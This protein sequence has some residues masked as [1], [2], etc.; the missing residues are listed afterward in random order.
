MRSNFRM[1]F[2]SHSHQPYRISMPACTGLCRRIGPRG[3]IPTT[4][5]PL[6]GPGA[7]PLLRGVASVF[8]ARGQKSLS[9]NVTATKVKKKLMQTKHVISEARSST[10]EIL[11][12]YYIIS[13]VGLYIRCARKC[14][15]FISIGV[16]LGGSR[17]TRPP[18][19][20]LVGQRY[21]FAPQ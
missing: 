16:D 15:V 14:R 10:N 18:I 8:G 13:T 3:S 12:Y 11:S 4:D 20:E 6:F 7:S 1:T 21:P 2:F 17:G 5:P 9:S 19:I